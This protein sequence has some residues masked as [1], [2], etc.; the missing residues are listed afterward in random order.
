MKAIRG[1]FNFSPQDLAALR[2]SVLKWSLLGGLAGVLAGTASALF[3]T[4][5]DWATST[6]LAHPNLLC[7]LPLAGFI[8][9]WVYHH[10]G[11]TASQG[12]N[13]VIEEV[14]SNRS[15]ITLRMAP[16]VLAGTVLTHLFGGSA[17]REGTAIQMG[18]SLADALRRAL[19]LS[20]ED[21]RL[22][23][24]AGISGGFGSVFGTPVS[25]FIFGMEV[26]SV[27]RIRYVALVPCLVAAY[28]GDII[29][30]MWGVGHTH[31]PAMQSFDT[32]P[33][34]LLKVAAAGILFGLASTVF[35]ELTH[36]IKRL[37]SR[38]IH[39]PPLRPVVGGL[40][41]IGMVWLLN[42]HEYLGLGIPLILRSVDGSGVIALAFMLKLVFTAVTLGSGFLGGEV[43]P[44]FVIGS[45]LGY[46][47][48]IILQVEPTFLASIGFVAIFAGA[49]NTPLA[50]AIM[51]IE[52][53]GGASAEYIVLGCV[54]AYLAS[55]HRGIYTTQRVDSPKAIGADVLEGES[56]TE[57]A[58]RRGG[59]RSPVKH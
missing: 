3:L 54:M 10:F 55:G 37:L 1:I 44:L 18:A 31:Y 43:T 48:G 50:S 9:G 6:R 26:L 49:S 8:V 15:H 52:L 35:V 21:R 34:L 40:V 19:H 14:H 59:G 24:M 27:G 33:V 51:A 41:I 30:R 22:L 20:P 11:G 53:F 46:T 58:N 57:L 28:V 5:L 2:T 23:L 45:T 17:G 38:L 16:L 12:N 32:Q 7:V 42:T 13:L 36:G 39:Y 56:L 25:G 47:L 29:T 4:S